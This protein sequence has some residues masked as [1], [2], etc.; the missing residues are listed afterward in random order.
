MFDKPCDILITTPIS[1]TVLLKTRIINFKRLFYLVLES[2]NKLFDTF[3]DEVCALLKLI[4]NVLEHRTF[5][6]GVQMI[7]TSEEWTA[8]IEKLYIQLRS[9]PLVCIYTHLEAA[10]YGRADIQPHF[11]EEFSKLYALKG[12]F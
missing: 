8:P 10:L 5:D 11:V 2:A 9:P 6:Q 1:L 12:Q 3:T 4:E 7:V